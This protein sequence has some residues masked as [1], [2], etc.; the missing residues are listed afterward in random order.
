MIFIKNIG[1][2]KNNFYA[3]KTNLGSVLLILFLFL[4]CTGY[5]GNRGSIY[6][7]NK[8]LSFATVYASVL[9][10]DSSQKILT[11]STTNDDGLFSLKINN[12]LSS[13][14]L[15]CNYLGYAKKEI[16]ISPKT[17]FPIKIT[18]KPQSNDLSEIIVSEQKLPI[19]THGDT[20]V[21]NASQFRDSTETTVEELLRKLP[22]VEIEANGQIK[23][24]GKPIKKMMIEGT[25]MFGRQYSIGSKN[26]RADFIQS[27]EVIDHYQENQVAKDIISSEDIVLNLT[28]KDEVKSIISGV[29]TFG[30]GYGDEPKGTL[31][32]NIFSI[33]KKRKYLWISNDGNTG[34][35]YGVD[36]LKY[37]FS[38]ELNDPLTDN[39]QNSIIKTLLRFF[40]CY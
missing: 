10:K 29:V 20:I 37:T 16:S 39:I 38:F 21:Y 2:R 13:V 6:G 26:I 33:K 3:K 34:T 36:E 4:K 15:T 1:I 27:V 25:D 12:D 31:D 32:A 22:G 8:P 28:L 35:Q 7:D 14:L 24:G 11:F 18:M 9:D 5:L 30:L 23:V 19:N 40:L 17:T